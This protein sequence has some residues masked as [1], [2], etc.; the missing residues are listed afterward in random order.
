MSSFIDYSKELQHIKDRIINNISQVSKTN[1]RTRQEK[2]RSIENDFS[3]I[4]ELIDTINEEKIMW[5]SSDSTKMNRILHDT[6]NELKRLENRY[7]EEQNRESLL[8][9]VRDLEGGSQAQRDSLS[10]QKQA[11]DEGGE[12]IQSMNQNVSD[13][14]DI[15]TGILTEM[16]TQRGK[17]ELIDTKLDDLGSEIVIGEQVTE[18][19]LCRQ[20]R[21]TV[22]IWICI[23]II[24]I[25]FLSVF[26]YFVF[27]PQ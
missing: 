4:H 27:K 19:M 24:I 9:G 20:K 15:G 14:R 21:R 2:C 12:M 25:V 17:V 1:G 22:L 18:K 13:I 3:S 8:G 10:D 23:V 6:D 5:D 16:S 26:L 7:K 11:I